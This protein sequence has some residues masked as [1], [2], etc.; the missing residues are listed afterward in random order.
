MTS[1]PLRRLRASIA[2][3]GSVHGGG[4]GA[5][6][7]RSVQRGRRVHASMLV[8]HVHAAGRPGGR[9]GWQRAGAGAAAP[10][11]RACVRATS[12]ARAPL[13]R[14]RIDLTTRQRRAAGNGGDEGQDSGGGRRRQGL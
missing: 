11:V 14:A 13:A 3:P 8:M 5:L 7:S 1:P 6:I 4:G 2:V 10:C 12:E 9:A